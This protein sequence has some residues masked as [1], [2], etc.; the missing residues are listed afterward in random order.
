MTARALRFRRDGTA[1]TRIPMSED[2]E[3]RSERSRK[4]RQQSMLIRVRYSYVNEGFSALEAK[5]AP[6]VWASTTLISLKEEAAAKKKA[7][8]ETEGYEALPHG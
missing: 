3:E 2:S 4:Q 7:E 8:A 5:W 1:A 6:K